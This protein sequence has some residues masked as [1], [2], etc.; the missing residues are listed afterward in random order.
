MAVRVFHV[1]VVCTALA[2]V[3]K[4]RLHIFHVE[5]PYFF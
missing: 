1:L 2:F 4:V 3:I 5:I